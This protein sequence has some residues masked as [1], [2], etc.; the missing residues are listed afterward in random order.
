MPF[1]QIRISFFTIALICIFSSN[2]A[3]SQEKVLDVGE[4]LQ[5]EVSFGFIKL[6][7]V[8]FILSNSRKEGKKLF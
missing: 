8:K 6:G 3:Y 4:E 5:Y 7:Y 2:E 1:Q